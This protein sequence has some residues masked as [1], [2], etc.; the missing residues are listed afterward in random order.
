MNEIEYEVSLTASIFFSF[1]QINV[2]KDD[3]IIMKLFDWPCIKRLQISSI[4][5]AIEL[6][7][8]K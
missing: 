7:L 6:Y 4:K 3:E 8:I 5:P 2:M 1:S